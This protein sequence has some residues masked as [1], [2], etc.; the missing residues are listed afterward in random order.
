VIVRILRSTFFSSFIC[1]VG[2]HAAC[3]DPVSFPLPVRLDLNLFGLSSHDRRGGLNYDAML[4][5]IGDTQHLFY[6][7]ATG[8]GNRTKMGPLSWANGVGLGYRWIENDSGIL[9]AYVFGERMR[10][11]D[12]YSW[13]ASPGLEFLTQHWDFHINAYAPIHY[14]EQ[15]TINTGEYFGLPGIGFS[16]HSLIDPLYQRYRDLG[17]GADIQLGYRVSDTPLKLNLGGYYFKMLHSKEHVR[18]VTVGTQY[19]L[20]KRLNLSANYSHDNVYQNSFALGLG[21]R[22]GGVSD[23]TNQKYLAQRMTDPVARHLFGTTHNSVLPSYYGYEKL[24]HVVLQNNIFFFNRDVQ[25]RAPVTSL[26]QCTYEHPCGP[27]QFN[28]ETLNNI[29]QLQKGASSTLYFNGGDYVAEA[30]DKN[31]DTLI[32]IPENQNLESRTSNYMQI[33]VLGQRTSFHGGM[34]LSG[35]NR[36]KNLVFYPTEINHD[37]ALLVK[38]N[39]GN[40]TL[41]H[42]QVGNLQ[43]RYDN[44]I[45][46]SG[47]TGRLVHSDIFSKLFGVVASGTQRFD[48]DHSRIHA[49]SQYNAYR[50]E[51]A[52]GVS[53]IEHAVVNITHSK[54]SAVGDG[55]NQVDGVDV[56]EEPTR[57]QQEGAL[58]MDHCVV[59]VHSGFK[60]NG[61]QGGCPVYGVVLLGPGPARA[62]ISNTT[63]DANASQLSGEV[64]GIEL[65]QGAHLTLHGSTVSVCSHN[66]QLM[67]GLTLKDQQ[68]YAT[69]SDTTFE[70][71]NPP[72]VSLRNVPIEHN[73]DADHLKLTNTYVTVTVSG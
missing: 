32:V 2:L 22:F 11:Q 20:N 51:A 64:H 50:R 31:E 57:G 30:R 47:G 35:N 34:E 18:G 12:V 46:V 44:G 14:R 69:V 65:R 33:A 53:L 72:G 68:D 70:L 13:L 16:G 49:I 39:V 15:V 66:D 67:V 38:S 25:D 36:L 45:L 7:N 19:W 60:T 55:E 59:T 56:I 9:G 42:I 52:C 23:P 3:A 37:L 62:F 27:Q 10:S 6:I 4:P 29:G 8:Q 54:I 26:T 71:I 21:V 61:G 73:S 17:K 1:V 48:I 63:I 58:T 28:Q 41:D 43:H 5:L 40:F 24:S